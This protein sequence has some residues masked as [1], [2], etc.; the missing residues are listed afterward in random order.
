MAAIHL[1]DGRTLLASGDRSGVR[2]WDPL[3]GELRHT[4]LTGAPVHALAVGTGP[5]GPALHVHGPSGLAILTLD[6]RVL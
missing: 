3:T 1:A 5:T 6:Q 2:I 4:L